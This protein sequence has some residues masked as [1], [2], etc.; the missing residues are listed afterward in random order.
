MKK[1]PDLH[2]LISPC[3]SGS[4]PLLHAMD[5][6]PDITC[7][8]QVIKDGIRT[9]GKPNYDIFDET[10]RQKISSKPHIFNKETL[11]RKTAQECS[12]NIFPEYFSQDIKT[13][14]LARDPIQTWNSWKRL[15][16]GNFDLFILAYE[17]FLESIEQSSGNQYQVITHSHLANNSTIMIQKLCEYWGIQFRPEMLQWKTRF[18]IKKFTGGRGHNTPHSSLRDT[19]YF[20][21]TD[22]DINIT[23]LEQMQITRKFKDAFSELNAQSK[24]FLNI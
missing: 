3:R 11:G 1:V 6:H 18:D 20:Q 10:K 24:L 21:N 9:T 14:F 16:W 2:L 7:V 23:V 22:R 13:I 8:A 4:T 12:Y 15:N 5:Q 17:S 19:S